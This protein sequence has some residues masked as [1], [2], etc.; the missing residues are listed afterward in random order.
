MVWTLLGPRLQVAAGTGK[1]REAKSRSVVAGG[2][3]LTARGS[4]FLFGVKTCS[5]SDHSEARTALIYNTVESCASHG[6]IAWCGNQIFLKL[7]EIRY[8]KCCL[9]S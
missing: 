6:P 1:H 2:R 3:E 4:G 8:E 9:V 5:T 7:L